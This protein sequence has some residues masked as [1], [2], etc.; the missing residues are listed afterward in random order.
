MADHAHADTHCNRIHFAQGKGACPWRGYGTVHPNHGIV[1]LVGV[2]PGNNLDARVYLVLGKSQYGC[3][4]IGHIKAEQKTRISQ[5]CFTDAVAR[6]HNSIDARHEPGAERRDGL[7]SVR[8]IRASRGP[9]VLV[10]IRY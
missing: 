1:I 5:V 7:V 9:E 2:R 6:R 3:Y 10:S 4:R 8:F